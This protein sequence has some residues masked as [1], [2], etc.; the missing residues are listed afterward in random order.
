MVRRFGPLLAALITL[1]GLAAVPGAAHADDYPPAGLS[2]YEPE[3]TLVTDSAVWGSTA[4]VE[5]NTGVT[6]VS[7]T[8]SLLDEEGTV[9]VGPIAVPHL[10]N[11]DE[12]AVDPEGHGV[13]VGPGTYTLTASWLPTASGPEESDSLPLT[14][15]A[16]PGP[17]PVSTV[18][19][20][21]RALYDDPTSAATWTAPQLSGRFASATMTVTGPG[22]YR[23]TDVVWPCRT[24]DSECGRAATYFFRWNQRGVPGIY[25]A[26]AAVPDPW[27]RTVAVDLGTIRQ[28]G[29]VGIQRQTTWPRDRWITGRKGTT[30]VVFHLRLPAWNTNRVDQFAVSSRASTSVRHSVAYKV[31]YRLPGIHGWTG[32]RSIVASPARYRPLW[33]QATGLA[34]GATN[35]IDL[36]GRPLD[37]QVRV[38]DGRKIKLLGLMALFGGSHWSLT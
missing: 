36:A 22:G 32:W 21:T 18:K 8:W 27:G 1:V 35:R 25:H 26:T 12:F 9:V 4:E 23:R 34:F 6:P 19:P 28:Y 33:L 5:L 20:A 24:V 17:I 7:A 38:S 2:W 29:S 11:V 37:V 13:A 30:N 31:R 16:D 10:S 15:V 3:R 14:F